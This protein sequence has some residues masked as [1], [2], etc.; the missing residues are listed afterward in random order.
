MRLALNHSRRGIVKIQH[1]GKDSGAIHFRSDERPSKTMVQKY[2]ERPESLSPV[3]VCQ[4]FG[5]RDVE[6]YQSINGA[7]VIVCPLI[8]LNHDPSLI[9]QYY[10]HQSITQLSLKR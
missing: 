9:E 2:C 8:T 10:N 7:A 3:C 6:C 4:I 5:V 1:H